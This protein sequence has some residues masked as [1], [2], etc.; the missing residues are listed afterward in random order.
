MDIYKESSRIPNALNCPGSL[1][2]QFRVTLQASHSELSSLR[3]KVTKC[4][5][6]V[7]VES[8]S[9]TFIPFLPASLMSE[10]NWGDLHALTLF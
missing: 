7:Q 1:S 5:Q 3:S 10:E 6:T 2:G 8:Q 4:S 9:I